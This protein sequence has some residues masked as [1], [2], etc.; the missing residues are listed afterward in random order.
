MRRNAF[1]TTLAL[2]ALAL[3]ASTAAS[4]PVL[5]PPLPDGRQEIREESDVAPYLAAWKASAFARS[6]AA[7]TPATA[8]QQQYDVHWYDLNLTFTPATSTVSGTVR[9]KASVVGGPI[10]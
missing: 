10:A 4:R 7:A 3:A 8:N 6:R 1:R 2:L 9:M 5:F